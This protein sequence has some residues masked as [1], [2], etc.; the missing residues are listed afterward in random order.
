MYRYKVRSLT[1]L[2]KCSKETVRQ[3]NSEFKCD[4]INAC[5]TVSKIECDTTEHNLEI[6]PK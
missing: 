2:C 6:F 1:E 5:I 3:V 4:E